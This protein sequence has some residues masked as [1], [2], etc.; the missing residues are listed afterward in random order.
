MG[1][2]YFGR[3]QIVQVILLRFKSDFSGLTFIFWTCPK[4]FEPNQN[5]LVPSKIICTVQ[6]YFGPI[7]GQGM[8]LFTFFFQLKQGVDLIKI[9]NDKKMK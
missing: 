9:T 2:N 3:E 4:L 1:T 6:S 8:I 7:E 5:E